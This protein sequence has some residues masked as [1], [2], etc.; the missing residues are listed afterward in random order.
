MKKLAL[1]FA[2]FVIGLLAATAQT[3]Q[4]TGTVTSADDGSTLPGVSVS[5]KGTTI[6]TITDFEGKYLLSVPQNAV[7]L[8]FSFVGMQSLEASITGNVVNAQLRQDVVGVEEVIV[9][10]YGT[11]KR[12]AITGSISSIDAKDIASRNL[13]S[14][15]SV[16]EGSAPGVQ[17]NNTYGEPG[18]DPSIRIR[19][20][21]SVNGS[22]SPLYVVDGVAYTGNISDLNPQDIESMTVLKDAASAALYG[23][24]A[25][26]GVIIIT[27]KKGKDGNLNVNASVNIG[28]FTR[29]IKEFERMEVDEWMETM[30]TGYKNYKVANG[31]TETEAAAFSTANLISDV[32]KRNIYNQADDALYDGDGKL[33]ADAQTLSGYTDL[34]WSDYLERTGKREEY[35]LSADAATDKYDFYAS[36]GYLS[37]EGYTITS[38]LERFTGRLNANFTPKTWFKAGI[39]LNATTSQSNY[40]S[41]AEGTYY[42]N[43]FN[44]A[45][46]MAPVYPVFLHNDDGSYLLDESGEK[47]YDLSSSY[48]SSRH[49]VYELENNQDKKYRS[50]IKGQAYATISFLN[51]FEFTL[52]G[53]KSVLNTKQ[54]N[55]DNPEIGDGAGS[56]GRLY[57]YYY[58]YD[59]Y[60]LQ[61][62]LFWK[63][64]FRNHHV[65]VLAAHENYDYKNS[66]NYTAITGIKVGGIIENSNFS[67]MT[68]TEGYTNTYKTES[69]LARTRYNYDGKYYFDASM[70]RDG[71]SR[72]SSLS[73]WGNFYSAGASWSISKENFMK[74]V[75]FV[76]HLKLR[77]SYGEVGNDAGVGS[78]N[79]YPYM[80]LYTIEQNGNAG[81]FYRSN[82]ESEDLKWE[83]STTLDIA[84]EGRL[85]DR[86]NFSIDYFDKRS[87]DMLFDVVLPLSNGATENLANGAT[88]SKNIGT[89]SNKGLELAFDVDVMKTKD[90]RWNIGIDATF[91]KN[92]FI[93]LPN[94]DDILDGNYKY[95]EGKSIYEFW[96]YQYA[97]TDQMNG[98]ALFYIDDEKYYG[99]DTEADESKT[100]IDSKWVREVNGDYYTIN[101]TYAK[102]DWSGSALPDVYGSFNTLLTYKNFSFNALLTYSIGG[103]LYD[104]SYRSLM[105][106][107]TSSASAIHQDLDKAW[108]ITPDGIELS[109]DNR[110]DPNGT[111]RVDMYYDTYFNAVSDRWLHDASYLVVKNV[112][113]TY[114]MPK[115]YV[116]K[117]DISGLSF[118]LGVE[119]LATFT[120]KQGLNPQYNFSGGSD[121]T[122]VTAR[123][124]SFGVD[125]NL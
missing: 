81:A 12:E 70:R 125:I 61:Q 119:N 42:V 108:S 43:P 63:R 38:D 87:K 53:D 44:A 116:D 52:R 122:F 21:T 76:N 29:G 58:Q 98:D 15:A 36:L 59:V 39:N 112:S 121:R 68:S 13:S 111:P 55:Y 60:T 90:L 34:D 96:L 123:V 24:R 40:A 101:T 71:S 26:N 75:D 23:N 62:Q 120:A 83:T 11:A 104:S 2:V 19:G 14:A 113:L 107:S 33:V 6:G 102:K 91:L 4:I 99:N 3:K 72:F 86:M 106:V 22:N 97:G 115:K 80:A 92:E 18:S 45:R 25:S 20:F 88:I 5:V 109:S 94:H 69:Y 74:E 10:A 103:K 35:N 56:D 17:V 85:F 114:N 8:V 105:S 32:V 118:R 9:V 64:S 51:D 73:R 48:L 79:Y 110:I 89:L 41:S 50:N 27:T 124:F 66:Y 46:H 31:S 95:S 67:S 7:N 28:T 117:M 78:S 57:S 93:K 54:K 49:I 100:A 84:L 65:D 16:L 1:L 37:E 82:L 77:T 47:Q 30:W